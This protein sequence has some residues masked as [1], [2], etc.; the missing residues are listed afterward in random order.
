MHVTSTADGVE[1][2]F[3]EV[4]GQLVRGL[5]ADYLAVMAGEHAAPARLFPQ[6]YPD[7]PGATEDFARRVGPGLRDRKIEN[8]D[9]VATS[10]SLTSPIALGRV[11]A[12][13][14]LPVLTDLRLLIA[15]RLGIEADEDPIP[16]DQLGLIYVWLGGVQEELVSALGGGS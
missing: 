16:D 3:A 9:L 8:A 12:E 11:I 5:V 1:I 2:A 10:L 13:R 7:D 14:W 6:A 4:E 15:D